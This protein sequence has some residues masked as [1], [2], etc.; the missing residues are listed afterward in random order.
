MT[1]SSRMTLIL[2]ILAIVMLGIS[3]FIYQVSY[4]LMKERVFSYSLVAAEQ[5]TD[6]LHEQL[7][8]IIE[9][10]QLFAMSQGLDG[11]NEISNEESIPSQKQLRDRFIDL[12]E[13][14]YRYRLY[15]S[16]TIMDVN[17][18]ILATTDDTSDRQL[19]HHLLSSALKYGK[20]TASFNHQGREF[21]KIAIA[22]HDQE[23]NAWAVVQATSSLKALLRG[24][25]LPLNKLDIR[26]MDVVSTDGSILYSTAMFISRETAPYENE[27][28]DLTHSKIFL[29]DSP[30]SNKDI[31]IA[32]PHHHGTHSLLSW[33]LVLHLDYQKTFGTILLLRWW[34]GGGASLLAALI[35]VS[36][37]YLH[38]KVTVPL[39]KITASTMS[40]GA[41]NLRERLPESFKREFGL[42][43]R[44]F[45]TMADN[46]EASNNLLAMEIA[47]KEKAQFQLARYTDE[48]EGIVF[49]R[50][51]EYREANN[52]LLNEIQERKTIEKNLTNSR[53]MLRLV[54]DNIPALIAFIDTAGKFQFVNK[55]YAN[56]F[57]HPITSILHKTL[58]ET[59]GDQHRPEIESNITPAFKGESR[60]FETEL[61]RP[62]GTGLYCAQVAYEPYF[63]DEGTVDGIFILIMDISQRKKH[64][65]EI[66][67]Q[68][69]LLQRILEGI[70]ATVI[71][72]DTDRHEITWANANSEG[73]LGIKAEDLVGKKCYHHLCKMG[74][75]FHELG[76]P[77]KGNE[78]LHHEFEMKLKDGRTISIT[79]TVLQETI[80]GRPHFIEILFDI[81]ERKQMELQLAHAQKME[82]IGSLAAG[83]AHEINT[84]SQYVRDNLTFIYQS[85]ESI[86]DLLDSC[87]GVCPTQTN[88]HIDKES[89]QMLLDKSNEIDVN[90]LKEELP[91]AI[92]QSNQGIERII[93]IVSA[94]KRFSHPGH[95]AMHFANVNEAIATTCTITKNEWKYFADVSYDFDEDLPPVKCFINDLNQVFLNIIVNAAH[96]LKEKFENKTSK[97]LI[98]ITT[99][100]TQDSAAI[101][102]SDNGIGIPKDIINRVFD[103]FFTT[104]ETGQGTGQGLSLCYSIIVNKHGGTIHI[105]S[106]E[107]EGTDCFISLPIVS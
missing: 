106:I 82:S 63:D 8:F 42:L 46:I 88:Q 71:I 4:R 18:N 43:A 36:L 49:D 54:T 41:G 12:F 89:I 90:F 47:E 77:A 15:E 66:L 87:M 32:A 53:A 2:T 84:P 75:N 96:A 86:N 60:L 38:R 73:L 40:F 48:L 102:F 30:Y 14:Q 23:G 51:Q 76:C 58:K 69:Q 5:I 68:K 56:Q 19:D 34:I 6:H 45:N 64:E 13:N 61:P 81:S 17:G 57:N 10:M 27:I 37:F 72:I 3:A 35:L 100:K 44:S 95:D 62:D 22:L 78:I 39:E 99:R 92:E 28:K 1:I 65:L 24:G 98:T 97:G 11:K 25:W 31:L 29:F 91:L 107:G 21:L 26:Q 9:D 52:Q 93:T 33:I 67:Q 83:I 7:H 103:P 20:S 70:K 101:V 55:Q 94:M 104:K 50:T 16:V 80:D 105:E 59:L 74:S 79:K 85:M